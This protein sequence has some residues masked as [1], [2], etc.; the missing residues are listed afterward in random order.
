MSLY[1]PLTDISSQGQD[2]L[3]GKLMVNLS[4]PSI[5]LYSCMKCSIYRRDLEY[6]VIYRRDLEYKVMNSDNKTIGGFKG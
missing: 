5:S 6:K 3:H 2:M 4:V 1:T